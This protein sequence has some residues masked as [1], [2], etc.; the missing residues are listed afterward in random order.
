MREDTVII[1][2]DVSAVYNV[3]VAGMIR[4][5]T[6]PWCKRRSAHS[7]S[8]HG[9]SETVCSSNS[10]STEALHPTANRLRISTRGVLCSVIGPL[11]PTIKWVHSGIALPWRLGWNTLFSPMTV[12]SALVEAMDKSLCWQAEFLVDILNRSQALCY[13]EGL[14]MVTGALSL[15]AERLL[16]WCLNPAIYELY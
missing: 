8:G 11:L 14:F 16:K 1:G 5:L 13:G 9:A 6:L 7:Q 2:R 15:F 12:V 10:S 3:G 4:V